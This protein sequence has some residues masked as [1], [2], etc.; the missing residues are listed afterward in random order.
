M[1]VLAHPSISLPESIIEQLVTYGLDG[2]EVSI[3]RTSRRKW[4]ITTN[5]PTATA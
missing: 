2:I 4:N 3:R 1:A 5:S